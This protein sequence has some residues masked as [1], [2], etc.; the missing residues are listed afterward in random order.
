MEYQKLQFLFLLFLL[1]GALLLIVLLLLPYLHALLLAV[2][3]AIV[4][5][6]LYERV[7][8]IW[9]GRK[10]LAAFSTVVIVFVLLLIPILFFG[11]QIFQES[12]ELYL[13]VT[14]EGWRI[15]VFDKIKTMVESQLRVFIPDFSIRFDEYAKQIVQWTVEHVRTI[16]SGLAQFALTFFLALFAFYYLLKDGGRLLQKIIALSPL[17]DYYDREI[18]R[19]LQAAVRAVVKGSFTVAFIQAILTGI[20][21]AVFGISNATLWGSVAFLFALI[22]GIGTALLIFPAAAFLFFTG[23]ELGALG[24]AAWG[25]LTIGLIENI[26]GPR[27][28]EREISLHPFLVLLSVL[29]GITFFGLIGFLLGPLVLSFLVT[30]LNIYQKE[31]GHKKQKYLK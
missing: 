2:A 20:G 3:L 9:K 16:F 30:M 4:F 7:L 29:G 19:T 23:H 12:K 8:I 24:L 10:G 15:E 28:I 31:F 5:Q 18:F 1:V 11:F 13:T 17:S 22:P 21:F 26:L 25:V 14:S 6:P 27:L